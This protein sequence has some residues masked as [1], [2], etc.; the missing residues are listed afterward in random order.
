MPAWYREVTA[1]RH[2]VWVAIGMVVGRG[3]RPTHDALDVL[4]GH[5]Y[6]LE[7]TLDELA[8]DLV[9]GRLTLDDLSR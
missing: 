1:R 8:D 6:A 5:A 2:H 9:E 3:R 7:V 4:R